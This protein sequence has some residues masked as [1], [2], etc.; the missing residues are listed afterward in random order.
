MMSLARRW[1]ASSVKQRGGVG[2]RML[3]SSPP[4]RGQDLA[5]LDMGMRAA[6]KTNETLDRISGL[7]KSQHIGGSTKSYAESYERIFGKRSPRAAGTKLP[8]HD[9]EAAGESLLVQKTNEGAPNERQRSEDAPIHLM[10]RSLPFEDVELA[11][12]GG[13][14]GLEVLWTTPPIVTKVFPGGAADSVGIQAGHLLLRLQ[15]RDLATKVGC[16]HEAEIEVLMQERPLRLRISAG[17]QEWQ[18]AFVAKTAVV[19]TQAGET[20]TK[21]D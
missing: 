12:A 5:D 18:D 11:P 13:T 21:E 6:K 7:Y 3:C 9:V 16:L 19:S 8:D 1:A 17:T 20:T 4:R 15:D 10:V 14:L 2:M